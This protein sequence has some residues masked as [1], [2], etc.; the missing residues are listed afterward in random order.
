MHSPF[1]YQI[2]YL[3]G[4][5]LIYTA[6]PQPIKITYFKIKKLFSSFFLLFIL[7]QLGLGIN[8]LEFGMRGD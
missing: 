5:N 4:I 6:F 3:S 1:D 7:I 2:D 8:G